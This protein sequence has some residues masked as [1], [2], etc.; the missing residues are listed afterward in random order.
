MDCVWADSWRNTTSKPFVITET[1]LHWNFTIF[2]FFVILYVLILDGPVPGGS[3]T[4][5]MLLLF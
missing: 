4:T 2:F 1:G 3:G 5:A